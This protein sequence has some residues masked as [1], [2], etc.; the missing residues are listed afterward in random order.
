MHCSQCGSQIPE[1]SQFCPTCGCATSPAGGSAFNPYASPAPGS[2]PYAPQNC[3]D[4]PDYLIGNIFMLICCCQLLGIIGVV[5]S[6]LTKS[7]KSRG[8][9]ETALRHSSTAKTL[10]YI[11]VIGGGVVTSLYIAAVIAS[12]GV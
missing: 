8:D 5:Y 9:Y 2:Y 7:A 6:A 1:N 3:S 4:V 10:F 11:G 12:A